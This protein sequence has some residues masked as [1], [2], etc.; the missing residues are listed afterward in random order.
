MGGGGV[1]FFGG[2]FERWGWGR[3]LFGRGWGACSFPGLFSVMK[4]NQGVWALGCSAVLALAGV[5]GCVR[6]ERA[7]PVYDSRY[8]ER[9]LLSESQQVYVRKAF[10][11]TGLS[12]KH[13]YVVY[14]DG[15]S[16]YYF[17]NFFDDR[18]RMLPERL[19]CGVR[20]PAVPPVPDH[21]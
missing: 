19:R 11:E 1:I 15:E 9:T 18:N 20:V 12:L 7:L 4:R 5:F 2:L 14:F 16:Y 13:H 10:F 3:C 17:D 8:P 21:G 6:T